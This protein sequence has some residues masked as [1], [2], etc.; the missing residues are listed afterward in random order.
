[1]NKKT[2]IIIL[3]IVILSIILIL[4][5]LFFP[6]NGKKNNSKKGEKYSCSITK[7]D[8]YYVV[9]YNSNYG[10]YS[11]VDNTY[12][13]FDN[14]NKLKEVLDNKKCDI[15]KVDID[16]SSKNALVMETLIDP[17]VETMKVED[18]SVKVI[19]TYKTKNKGVYNVFIMPVDK[20][21][22][23]YDIRIFPSNTAEGPTVNE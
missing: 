1:M 20:D 23:N 10:D 2:V 19:I 6:N 22:E 11:M 7:K 5:G 8:K 12:E 3:L 13:V 18:K 15:S 4:L 16:F 17:K 9:S 21:I 14:K